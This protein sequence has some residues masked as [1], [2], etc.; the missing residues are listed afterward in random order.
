MQIDPQKQAFIELRGEGVS[1]SKIAKL[2]DVS[3]PTLIRWCRELEIELHNQRALVSDEIRECFAITRK[4]RFQVLAKF[5][6]RL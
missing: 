5:V 1:L 4:N 6:D 2:L 3:K